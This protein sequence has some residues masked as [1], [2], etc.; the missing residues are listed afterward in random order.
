M[1]TSSRSLPTHVNA[2][3]PHSENGRL[4]ILGEGEATRRLRLQLERIGPHLRTVLIKGETGTG[5]ELVARALHEKSPG[6]DGPFV[7]CRVADMED[8][9]ADG[10]DGGWI[11]DLI[12][13]SRKGTLFLDRIEETPARV[14]AY[15][16]AMLDK[17]CN[18]QLIATS[19]LDLRVMIASGQFRQDLYHRI[20]MIEITVEPLRER[21]ED[22]PELATSCLRRFSALYGRQV[23]IFSQEALERLRAHS[24]PGNIRELENVVLNAVLQCEGTVLQAEE[25]NSLKRMELETHPSAQIGAPEPLQRVIERHVFDI[26]RRCGGNKLRAAEILGISRSTLYRMLDNRST[27]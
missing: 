3:L 15:L 22:I 27:Q 13:I 2:L 9:A 18:K 6:A 23:T 1:S 24:W 17:R 4:E 25:L 20:A 11:R 19:G 14:Q 8:A 7:V 16:V 10:T 21:A 5:K 12:K 26:L